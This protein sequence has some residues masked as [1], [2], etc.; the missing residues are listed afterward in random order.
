[1]TAADD[2]G[3]PEDDETI[4]RA[5]KALVPSQSYA[6]ESFD[7]PANITGPLP[8]PEILLQYERIAPG[9][10]ERLL[11]LVER[12]QSFALKAVRA[13]YTVI[14]LRFLIVAGGVIGLTLAIV[15]L[16]G[17]SNAGELWINVAVAIGSSIAAVAVTRTINSLHE[18]QDQ[19][20][21]HNAEDASP[22]PSN[23]DR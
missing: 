9:S 11:K 19:A 1:M 16:G 6:D 22:S 15:S 23:H 13:K 3:H 12:E 17:R 10:S 21:S 14:F 18:V 2:N 20:D 5:D 4:R 8:D 7:Y